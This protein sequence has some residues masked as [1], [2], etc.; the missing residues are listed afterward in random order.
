MVDAQELIRCRVHLPETALEY[1]VK[2]GA[3][4]DPV[5]LLHPWFG[6]WQFWQRTVAALPEYTCYLVDLYSPGASDSWGRFARP[7]GLAEAVVALLDAERLERCTLV[8]NSLGGIT[9]QIVAA[10]VPDRVQK[11]VL[12]GTG[13]SADGLK[14]D[15]R[16]EID[17][18]LSGDPDGSRCEAFVARLFARRPPLEELAVYVNAVRTA[19]R[20]FMVAVLRSSLELDL[21]PRLH[22]ITARTLVVRGELDA[23][24]TREHVC[25][26]LR[27]ISDSVAIE[28]PGAGHSVMVDSA[29]QF[30]RVLRA[31]LQQGHVE[32]ATGDPESKST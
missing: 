22:A 19:N 9:A 31:F 18:W 27:G 3:S 24:R 29:D 4:S 12:V 28:L 17:A 2:P 5:V 26:L 25:D 7:A 20:D 32:G 10:T 15:Y 1:R 14:P 16:A 30:D 11:L 23:G 13:A 8:G 21:R 6:C